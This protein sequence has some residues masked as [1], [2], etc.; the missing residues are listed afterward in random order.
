MCVIRPSPGH[1]RGSLDERVVNARGPPVHSRRDDGCRGRSP[2][3]AGGSPRRGRDPRCAPPRPPPIRAGAGR[4]S[5]SFPRVADQIFERSTRSEGDDPFLDGG[6]RVVVRRGGGMRVR[7]RRVGA[8]PRR[9]ARPARCA[10][11]AGPAARRAPGLRRRRSRPGRGRDRDPATVAPGNRP[12]GR[13]RRLGDAG[14]PR[15]DRRPSPRG[16]PARLRRER[17]ARAEDARG[18][19]PSGRGDAPRRRDRRPA[20]GLPL[21]RAARTRGAAP[22]A[23]R[24]GSPRPLP[25]GDWQRPRRARAHGCDRGRRGRAPRGPGGRGPRT[26]RRCTPTAFPR[27]TAPR[28]TWRCWSGT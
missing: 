6:G 17:L 20:G 27:S 15:R 5:R 19:D 1:R 25:A 4:P 13:R 16:D 8:A 10:P 24:L 3:G 28:G 2:R 11:A 22:I 7:E 18:I 26:D 9:G 14:D 21:H 23:H 12:T